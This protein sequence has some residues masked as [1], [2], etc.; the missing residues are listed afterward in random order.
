[1]KKNSL[2]LCLLLALVLSA[3]SACA[4]RAEA[5]ETD[6]LSGSLPLLVNKDYPVDEAFLPADLV[7]LTDVLDTSLVRVRN[8]G[9]MAV[10]TAAEAL[11]VMLEAAAKDGVKNWQINT[12]YRSISEQ[13]NLLENKIKSYRKS[14]PSWSR[15]KALSAALRT[16]AEPGCSEHHLG[17]AFDITAKGASAFKGTKQCK[18]LH[19]H[20]WDYGFIVRYQ[21]GKEEIT[22][23]SAEEWHIRYVGPEHARLIR[24]NNYCLEEYLAS[25]EPDPDSFLV[26]GEIEEI[27][28][29]PLEDFPVTQ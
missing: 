21:E 23:F 16:V 10:R 26:E 1:M 18:W 22:G 17:L 6:V 4:A 15:S 29:I 28:E 25:V 7:L 5:A 20:C 8:K 19:L 9:I 2:L 24:D 12:A 3:F 13:K 11:E 27:G 14:N